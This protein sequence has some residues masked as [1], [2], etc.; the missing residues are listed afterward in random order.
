MSLVSY[1]QKPS[2]GQYIPLCHFQ[3]LLFSPKRLK[4]SDICF[5]FFLCNKLCMCIFLFLV[6]LY[7]F[8]LTLNI[9]KQ[10]GNFVLF[11]FLLQFAIL[12]YGFPAIVLHE[13]LFNVHMSFVCFGCG[14][15]QSICSREVNEKPSGQKMKLTKVSY[16]ARNR[17]K[18][19]AVLR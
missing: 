3:S 18:P 12:L 16:N 17:M 14:F 9:R 6:S 13:H 5:A 19:S 15:L 7:A 2:F 11:F 8:E 10:V 4:P 1:M